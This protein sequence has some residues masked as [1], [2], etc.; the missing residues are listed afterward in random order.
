MHLIPPA[1]GFTVLLMRP[2]W[3]RFVERPP[4]STPA[5][6]LGGVWRD[7]LTGGMFVLAI[8]SV[9]L[10]LATWR[11]APGATGGVLLGLLLL[12]VE[13]GLSASRPKSS[14]R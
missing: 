14:S 13:L 3:P 4:L 8:V 5:A 6:E 2:L 1:A 11:Y 9:A 12:A 7:D 10:A